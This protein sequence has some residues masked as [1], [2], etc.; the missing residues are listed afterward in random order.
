ML[1]WLNTLCSKIKFLSALV[2]L[3]V[4]FCVYVE[5][6]NRPAKTWQISK[7]PLDFYCHNSSGLLKTTVIVR[8]FAAL[9]ASNS[10]TYTR[11]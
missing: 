1:V 5:M 8:H 4:F 3:F 10:C 11:Y 7:Q 6:G 9:I 2:R